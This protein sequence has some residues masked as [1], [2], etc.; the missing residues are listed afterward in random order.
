MIEAKKLAYADMLRYVADPKFSRRR[1]RRCS[2]RTA[3]RQRAPTHRPGEGACDVKPSAFDGLTNS[4]GG[5]TIYLSRHRQGRQHRLAD[6]EPLF[7][8]RQRRRA[9]RQPASCCTIAARCSRSRRII[10][11]CSRRASGRCTRSFRRSWRR[12]TSG[13]ASASWAGST[14]RRPTR[15]SS[16]TSSI[17]ASTFRRRSRPAASRSCP[18]PAATCMRNRSSRQAVRSQLQALGHDVTVVPPRTGSTFGYGQAVMSDGAGV[19]FG[20]SEPRHDGAAIPEA[21]PVFVRP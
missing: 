14:R 11:T 17:T 5:D 8:L 18:S 4:G 19:H 10:R 16:P 21:P 2:A 3:R 9:S 6:S 20:A 12:E 7:E 15:S 13:S 1:C